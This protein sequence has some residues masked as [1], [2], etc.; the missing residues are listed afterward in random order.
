LAKRAF[1]RLEISH[2]LT[3]NNFFIYRILP[4]PE[5]IRLLGKFRDRVRA[6]RVLLLLLHYFAPEA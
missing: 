5:G 1:V 2:D 6:R 3:E 4:I